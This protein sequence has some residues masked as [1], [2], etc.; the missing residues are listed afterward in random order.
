MFVFKK[1]EVKVNDYALRIGDTTQ[2]Y[3]LLNIYVVQ[4]YKFFYK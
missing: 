2:T 1:G 4:A 3:C